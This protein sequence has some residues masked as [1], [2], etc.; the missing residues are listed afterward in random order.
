MTS[1][2]RGLALVAALALGA[3][4]RACHL[5]SIG[6]DA[7]SVGP[8]C[9]TFAAL[10]VAGVSSRATLSK[11]PPA[12]AGPRE[13]IVFHGDPATDG[14]SVGATA[15]HWVSSFDVLLWR[16]DGDYA[17]VERRFP[18]RVDVVAGVAY[19][20]GGADLVKRGELV[21]R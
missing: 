12:A 20:R 1:G 5:R 10:C 14:F 6:H 21:L 18:G 3:W 7:A 4:L 15:N 8:R 16:R 13:A 17:H 11:P 9:R 2:V 19:L